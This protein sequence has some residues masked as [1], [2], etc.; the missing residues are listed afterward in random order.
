MWYHGMICSEEKR[1]MKYSQLLDPSDRRNTDQM[2]SLATAEEEEDFD[3]TIVCP[4]LSQG[5]TSQITHAVKFAY[6]QQSVDLFFNNV[7]CYLSAING[8]QKAI[9]TLRSPQSPLIFEYAINNNKFS[10][11]M[12]NN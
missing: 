6:G 9:G 2:K 3:W 5:T 8:S 4:M 12:N 11:L 1:K 7:A 10:P